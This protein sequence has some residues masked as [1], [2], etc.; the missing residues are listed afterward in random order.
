VKARVAV[1]AVLGWF[2]W[3]RDNVAL[4]TV[5]LVLIVIFVVLGARCGGEIAVREITPRPVQESTG[6]KEV[7]Y[8][9]DAKHGVACWYIVNTGDYGYAAISCI[10]DYYVKNAGE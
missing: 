2:A 10:P 5:A 3:H 8:L 9:Y 6:S 4:V 1:R 7:H